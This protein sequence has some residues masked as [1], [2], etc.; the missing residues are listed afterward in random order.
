MSK[1]KYHIDIDGYIGEYYYSKRLVK[2]ELSKHP[3]QLV[4]VRMNSLGGSLD[5]GLD[6]ADRFAEHG[7]VEVDLFGFNASAATLATLKAKVVRISSSGFYLIHKVM[8]WVDIWGQMN[9]DQLAKAIEDLEKNKEENQKMDLVIAQ[10]YSEKT[11]KDIS[12]ILNLMKVGGWLT[13]TE[14]KEWGFVNEIIKD[15]EKVNLKEMGDKLNAFG[16]PTN[17]VSKSNFFTNIKTSHPMKKQPI[18]INAILKVERLESTDNEGVFL[19]ED[20]VNAINSEIE[21]QETRANSLET[22]RDAAETRATTAETQLTEKD[23]EIAGLKTQV[24][25]LKKNPGAQTQGAGKQTDGPTKEDEDDFINVANA[26]REL[27]NM[28]P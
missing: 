25:N 4:R 20:Q 17:F 13:A 5:H 7:N 14:A 19:T 23:N 16:L 15:K 18:K 1:V 3:D 2:N 26:S 11:G 9:A 24:E 28:L 8:N 22:E 27:Y 12:E 6:I 21:T 10:M